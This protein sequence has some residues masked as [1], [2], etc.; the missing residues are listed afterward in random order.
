MERLDIGVEIGVDSGSSNSNQ[1][2][3]VSQGLGSGNHDG[4]SKCPFVGYNNNNQG[5]GLGESWWQ[6]I[7]RCVGQGYSNR[8]VNAEGL[9]SGWALTCRKFNTHL[10]TTT[11]IKAMPVM[12]LLI[13]LLMWSVG[14][15]PGAGYS[16]GNSELGVASAS[17]GQREYGSGLAAR[18]G[19]NSEAGVASIGQQNSHDYRN[20]EVVASVGQQNSHDYRNTEVVASIGQQNSHDHRNDRIKR[21]SHDHR[22]TEAGVVASIGQQNS[23]DYRKH[24]SCCFCWTTKQSWPSKWPYQE[25]QSQSPKHWSWSCC[26]CWTTKQPRLSERW[27]RSCFCW[28]KQP[29]PSKWPHET[30]SRSWTRSRTR[31]RLR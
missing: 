31:F 23:H 13:F 25:K 8:N 27:S 17:D 28:T 4:I 15:G 3:G 20:A 26:F 9:G 29:R 10:V 7:N 14:L 11:R 21:N 6:L 22:N 2:I 24:W 30:L 16:S 19:V 5:Q 1:G 12:T 18:M